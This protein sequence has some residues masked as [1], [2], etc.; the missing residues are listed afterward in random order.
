[1]KWP[2]GMVRFYWDRRPTGPFKERRID[3]PGPVKKTGA[4]CGAPV[5]E[6]QGGESA[7]P[8]SAENLRDV[9]HG[10]FAAQTLGPGE[11]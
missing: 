6:A 9:R 7:A 11:L 10:R 5:Q 1:M 2:N 8:R 3:V 4:L